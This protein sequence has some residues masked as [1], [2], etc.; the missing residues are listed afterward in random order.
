M[1]WLL[2]LLVRRALLSTDRSFGVGG[3]AAELMFLL[4]PAL[5]PP[6]HHQD[7]DLAAV[8][9]LGMKIDMDNRKPL[10]RAKMLI[11]SLCKSQRH[12]RRSALGMSLVD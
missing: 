2:L 11:W 5:A 1:Y 3:T 9:L 12:E 10:R 7:F 4:F 8:N 6:Q